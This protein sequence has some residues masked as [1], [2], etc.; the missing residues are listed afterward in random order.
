MEHSVLKTK[1]WQVFLVLLASHFI[2]WFVS[3]EDVSEMLKLFG[4]CV[5]CIWLGLLGNT[6]NQID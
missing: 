1:T 4:F 2:S 5:F 3:D 6:L